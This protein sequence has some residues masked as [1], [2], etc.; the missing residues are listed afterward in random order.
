MKRFKSSL[1]SRLLF[2][3]FFF[4][5]PAPQGRL[6]T[7]SVFSLWTGSRTSLRLRT[8][9]SWIIPHRPPLCPAPGLSLQTR[10]SPS[11]RGAAAV[12]TRTR[13]PHS[14][15]PASAQRARRSVCAPGCGARAPRCFYYSFPRRCRPPAPSYLP[16]DSPVRR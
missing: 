14:G 6:D 5:P 4:P 16:E 10:Q 3:P 12:E 1:F 7:A 8:A 13:T 2:T 9:D 11:L 15:P